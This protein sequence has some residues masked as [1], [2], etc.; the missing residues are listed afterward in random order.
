MNA[1]I[2]TDHS[3]IAVYDSDDKVSFYVYFSYYIKK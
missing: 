2:F 1:W 3:Y